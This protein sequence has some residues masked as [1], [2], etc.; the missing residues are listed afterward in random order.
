MRKS[1]SESTRSDN[2]IY[3][4]D[5]TAEHAGAL[6]DGVRFLLDEVRRGGDRLADRHYGSS[7]DHPGGLA[8]VVGTASLSQGSASTSLVDLHT[9]VIRVGAR[10]AVTGRDLGENAA[11]EATNSEATRMVCTRCESKNVVPLY[12]AC[13]DALSLAKF[14]NS[15][16]SP[17]GVEAQRATCLAR[18]EHTLRAIIIAEST[19]RDLP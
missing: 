6:H 16:S 5:E 2:F 14:S 11:A 12:L 3:A 15:A 4:L 18:R 17:A 19:H 13:I 10:R 9:V 1:T 8:C 7:D